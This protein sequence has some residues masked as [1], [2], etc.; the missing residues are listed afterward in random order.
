MDVA[1]EQYGQCVVLKVKG[2]ISEDTVDTLNQS[3]R[4]H[5]DDSAVTDLVVSLADVTYLDSVGL[6]YLWTLQEQL[7]ERMRYLKL[8]EPDEH[9]RKI[10]EITRMESVFD[11][12][13]DVGEVLKAMQP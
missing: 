8:V 12:Y 6:E 2:E 10:L 4:G 13:D 11:V 5:L 7:V 3:V 9:V 1:E